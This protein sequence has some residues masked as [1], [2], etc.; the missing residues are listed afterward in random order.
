MPT[1]ALVAGAALG[2]LALLTGLSTGWAA[3]NGGAFADMVRVA[4]Y[5][6]LFVLVVV[7]APADS[8]R[9]WLTGLA[10]GLAVVA[11]LA[12]G[13]RLQPSLLPSPDLSEVFP[14][15]RARLAYPL[16]YWNG[17][18]AVAA[19]GIALL[20]WLGADART[21]A[22]RAAATALIPV[23]ALV[24]YFTSS[25]G[26]ALSAAVG[27]VVLLALGPA[28]ARTGAA[29]VLGGGASAVLI[30]IAAGQEALRENAL[31]STAAGQGDDLTLA[32]LVAIVA[33]AAL[34]LAVDGPL[35]RFQPP[36]LSR[37]AALAAAGAAVIAV[38]IAIIAA[39]PGERLDEF[40]DP[41][42]SGG[43]A[44][45]GVIASD[46]SRG[47][48]G[49]RWQFWGAALDAFEQR[50]ALGIGASDY[51]SWW[52]RKGS[53][54]FFVR[55]AHSLYLETAGELGIAGLTLL[56]T[57]MATP[58]VVLARR[59]EPASGAGA[60]AAVLACAA[61]TAAFEW[62]WELTAAFAPFVFA[63]A[64]VCGPALGP[65][66]ERR[67]R[68]GWGIAT[69][70]AAWA[71]IIVAAISLLA[72]ARIEDSRE[73]ARKGDLATAEDTARD[74]RAIEPWAAEP[75]LQIALVR[76]LRRDLDGAIRQIRAA[77]DRSPE[78]WRLWLVRARLETRAGNL[79]AARRALAEAR[80]LNP[81]FPLFER[82]S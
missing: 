20:A 52:N 23:P 65:A 35:Q 25:R 28:R 58:F 75:R 36:R 14:S 21:R 80:R 60:A 11:A 42:G 13:S 17:L 76:E 7:A 73:A 12:L 69:L 8:A 67:D 32:L 74:A 56:L 27:V 53:I 4:G 10:V 59:R 5:L 18:G 46:F 72:D 49:G 50:P 19:I 1:A 37:P 54:R 70:C 57:F 77:I 3:D 39:S 2:A 71:A 33:V 66:G 48:S 41:P 47:G 63:A 79:P 38:A 9:F 24:L 81:R 44:P 43:A 15:A 22:G 31:N 6:G 40:N 26:G 61:V 64:L 16:D 82:P 29:L 68:F 30:S 62:T 34:R 55:D 78:D 51:E 45:G